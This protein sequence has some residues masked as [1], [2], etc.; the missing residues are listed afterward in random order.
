MKYV[1]HMVV[2][3]RIDIEV[4]AENPE[5]AYHAAKD[6]FDDAD[7]SQ[8]EIIDGRP[9]HCEDEEGRIVEEY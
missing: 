2:D 6:A 7:L 9:V 1:V 8:M 4:E 5:A 3:G